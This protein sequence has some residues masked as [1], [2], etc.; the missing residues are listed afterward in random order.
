MCHD[1]DTHLSC[2]SNFVSDYLFSLTQHA[3]HRSHESSEM[4]WDAW[5]GDGFFATAPTHV[6]HTCHYWETA[7]GQG[8]CGGKLANTQGDRQARPLGGRQ[9]LVAVIHNMPFST[10]LGIIT[11]YKEMVLCLVEEKHNT[12]FSLFRKI[13]LQHPLCL[14]AISISKSIFLLLKITL[15]FPFLKNPKSLPLSF[16]VCFLVFSSLFS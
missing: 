6:C 10:E 16:L 11:R 3:L 13:F 7:K 1:D 8:T 15:L 14:P 5:G 9:D 12:N 2:F 4:H